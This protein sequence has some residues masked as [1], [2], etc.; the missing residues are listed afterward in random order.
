MA[1]VY[2]RRIH[3]MSVIAKVGSVCT[4]GVT[5]QLLRLRRYKLSAGLLHLS[6]RPQH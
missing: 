4:M 6:H 3:V 2:A 5:W 1:S